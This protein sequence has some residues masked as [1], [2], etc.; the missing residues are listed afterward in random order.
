[1]DA[2]GRA[3]QLA[4]LPPLF[5]ELLR[6]ELRA[7]SPTS[8]RSCIGAP[9]RWLA[10]HGG[11]ARRAA[12][13]RRRQ[14]PGTSPRS[15][16]G[17]RWFGMMIERRDRGAAR[18]SSRRCRASS[19]KRRPEL[20]ARV[21]RRAA[22]ARRARPREAA[23]CSR[24]GRRALACA[25]APRPVRG[26]R[27]VAPSTSGG[28]AA[29]PSAHSTVRRALLERHTCSTRVLATRR[30]L[31]R[32]GPARGSSS[33]GPATSTPRPR[34]SRA[35]PAA[36]GGQMR[37]DG[38]RRRR[39]SR[40]GAPLPRRG[41]ARSA[42]GRRGDRAR[43]AARLV[44]SRPGGAAYRRAPRRWPC[45]AAGATRRRACVARATEAIDASAGADRCAPPTASTAR[46]C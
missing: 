26:Q 14:A 45:S 37:L 18:R 32:A 42:P 19:S 24:R 35:R 4:S 40:G 17:E 30:A 22:R 33:C 1:M 6:A 9:R 23:T 25:R 21:R 34:T 43:R 3:R 27:A 38:A 20:R 46:C 29:I 16:A 15:C 5:A 2:A 11:D 10:A 28:C 12:A 31:V 44:T 36:A 8:C 41:P 7:S 39:A 13:R